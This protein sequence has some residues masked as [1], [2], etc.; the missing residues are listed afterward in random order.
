MTKNQL[1]WLDC[2]GA[3]L[4]NKGNKIRFDFI[5]SSNFVSH[6]LSNIY[7][8]DIKLDKRK[9]IKI[10]RKGLKKKINLIKCIWGVVMHFLLYFSMKIEKRKSCLPLMSER[11]IHF[12]FKNRVFKIQF[13]RSWRTFV[14]SV[15]F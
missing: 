11:F 5:F 15:F 8:F 13:F 7:L 2:F 12:F 14:L 1:G 6:I 9:L 3:E 10:A 4:V